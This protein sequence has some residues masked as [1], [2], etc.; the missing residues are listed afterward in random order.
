M[1]IDE[2][3]A[4][5][6]EQMLARRFAH[7][8][9]VAATAADI[10]TAHGLDAQRAAL[11]GL[12][13]DLCRDVPP[14]RIL[15]MAVAFGIVREEVGIP[16]LVLLHGPVAAERAR[17]E[18]GIT[19]A[20]VLEAIRVHTTG[21]PEMGPLAQVVLVADRVEPGRAYPERES[22]HQVALRDLADGVRRVMFSSMQWLRESGIPIDPATLAT[23][24]VFSGTVDD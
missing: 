5:L 16:N 3:S 13:H 22:L 12:L 2:L 4:W 7:A 23:Y 14:D 11:A 17:T 19:D 24:E 15:Q 20:E 18:L 6:A 8:Q 9:R 21:S 1:Q 10:A